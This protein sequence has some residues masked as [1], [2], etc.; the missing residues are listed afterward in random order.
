LVAGVLGCPVCHRERTVRSG[1]LYW[2]SGYRPVA[3]SPAADASADRVTRIGALLAYAEGGL[4]FVLRGVESLVAA[5]LTGLA[6]APLVL[7]DPPDDRAAAYATII[8][9]A[10]VLPLAPNSVR[11]VVASAGASDAFYLSCMKALVPR[12]RLVGP[13]AVPVP[14]GFRELARDEEQWVAERGEA[15]AFIPLGRATTGG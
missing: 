7:L 9:D 13:A 8:R 4:P 11:G 5:G 1:V 15:I 10:P 6:E 12:G 2:S 14:Q 3:P